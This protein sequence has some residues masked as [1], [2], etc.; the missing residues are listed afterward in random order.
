MIVEDKEFRLVPNANSEIESTFYIARDGSGYDTERKRWLTQ[1]TNG[2]GYT[3]YEY[4][5][6]PRQKIY[7]DMALALA[8][9]PNPSGYEYITHLDGDLYNNNIDNLAWSAEDGKL[10]AIRRQ[11]KTYR[12]K[13]MLTGLE[14][15]KEDTVFRD[16]N[17]GVLCAQT[18]MG[19][20]IDNRYCVWDTTVCGE[21][22]R[23]MGEYKQFSSDLDNGVFVIE[24][25][26]CKPV[27][28]HSIEHLLGCTDLSSVF[29]IKNKMK[30]FREGRTPTYTDERMIPYGEW[31]GKVSDLIIYN[32]KV[33]LTKASWFSPYL[34][35]LN[36]GEIGLHLNGHSHIPD[37]STAEI[38][39]MLKTGCQIRGTY[40][41][42][43]LTMDAVI[44][45]V[46]SLSPRKD[47]IYDVT[48][49]GPGRMHLV[50]HRVM[51]DQFAHYCKQGKITFTYKDK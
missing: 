4:G 11:N 7:V 1:Y 24:G 47:S 15:N 36:N 9:I 16:F 20:F 29:E 38:R 32:P 18:A 49:M 46:S 12:V 39:T 51:E 48:V 14:T 8:W 6:R 2:N 40:L 41:K 30:F 34:I 23:S 19:K 3:F 31:E 22:P 13:D 26:W 33:R 25:M 50:K 43:L 28:F 27:L 10:I 17:S 35:E 21:C 45:Y 37:F 44:G 5:Q 42:Y